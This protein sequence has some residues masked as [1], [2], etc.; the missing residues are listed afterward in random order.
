MF[1]GTSKEKFLFHNTLLCI[2]KALEGQNV[3]VDLR[4]DAYVCGKISSVDG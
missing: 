3:T 1:V 2:V 4:N